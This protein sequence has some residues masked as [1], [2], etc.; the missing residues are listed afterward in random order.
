VTIAPGLAVDLLLVAAMIHD[1]RTRGSVHPAYWVGGSAVLASQ[2]LRVPLGR[3]DAWLAMTDWL[4]ALA[5]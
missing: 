1:R 5:P 4:L 2:L 3:T